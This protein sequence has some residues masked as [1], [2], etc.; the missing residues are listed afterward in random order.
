MIIQLH[1]ILLLSTFQL[2]Q[3]SHL[4]YLGETAQQLGVRFG[5]HT[6][7]FKGKVQFASF[8]GFSNHFSQLFKV[9]VKSLD[10]QVKSLK[11]GKG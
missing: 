2:S 10:T 8:R 7:C 6:D 1:V 11:S 3:I 4:Q 9:F 5:K